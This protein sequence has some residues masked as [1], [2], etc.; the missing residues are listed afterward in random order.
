MKDGHSK[1][2]RRRKISDK[3]EMWIHTGPH[4]KTDCQI[5]I[6]KSLIS[7]PSFLYKY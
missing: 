7:K 1:P 6:I 4:K 2:K 3:D 5:E